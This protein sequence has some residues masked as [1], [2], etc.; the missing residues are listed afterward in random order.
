MLVHG[1]V[2]IIACSDG[3]LKV[4]ATGIA[5]E[6]PIHTLYN[7]RFEADLPALMSIRPLPIT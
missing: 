6:Q 1:P 3:T 5:L 7:N 4:I 2:V